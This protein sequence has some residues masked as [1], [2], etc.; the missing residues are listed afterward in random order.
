MPRSIRLHL[1]SLCLLSWLAVAG[2]AEGAGETV[3]K[4]G[5]RFKNGTAAIG[6]ATLVAPGKL[7]T[8]CHAIRGAVELLLLHPEGQLRA[9]S[10][11]GDMRHDLCLLTVA[12]LRAPGAERVPSAKLTVGQTVFAL[13]YGM[14]YRLSVTEG[15]VTALYRLDNAYVVRTS[16]AFP[17]G[18]SGGGLFDQEGRLIGILTFRASIDDQLNYAVPIEWLERLLEGESTQQTH[19][20]ASIAFWEDDAPDQPAFLRAAWLE[21][22]RDWRQLKLVAVD[23]ALRE[24]DNAEAW[25]AMGRANVGLD[26]YREAVLALRSATMLE[27]DS[28]RAWYWLAVAYRWIG[29][30]H[31]FA[32]AKMRLAQLSPQ[33]VYRLMSTRRE[34]ED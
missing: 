33:L 12:E 32:D 28:P 13:G 18:A 4:L 21:Y 30:D 10:A 8:S 24:P 5:V 1:T 3:Y 22:A 27:P 29:L 34:T 31:Q 19:P 6:S 16:A 14:S 17:R 26:Q 11:Q 20:T 9:R 15:R 2:H 7:I 23:W 25:L